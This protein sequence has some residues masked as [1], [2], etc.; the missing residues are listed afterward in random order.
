MEWFRESKARDKYNS[1]SWQEMDGG[2][3]EYMLFSMRCS[4]VVA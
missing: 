2:N 1:T 4:V 3:I